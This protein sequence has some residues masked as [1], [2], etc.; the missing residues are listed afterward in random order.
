MSCTIRTEF[1]VDLPDVCLMPE[2]CVYRHGPLRCLAPDDNT[3]SLLVDALPDRAVLP[4]ARPGPRVVRT[5]GPV[6]SVQTPPRGLHVQPMPRG[7]QVSVDCSLLGGRLRLRV[8]ES[9]GERWRGID[10]LGEQLRRMCCSACQEDSLVGNA[11]V[12][13]LPQWNLVTRKEALRG[14]GAEGRGK[15]CSDWA[16]DVLAPFR[17][18][19]D[20][21]F[22]CRPCAHLQA[23]GGHVACS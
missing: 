3:P 17:L 19:F 4:C 23:R 10:D 9:S 11:R 2:P 16:S 15:N 18:A 5:T 6:D 1:A 21:G 12:R 7:V 20:H 13:P 22:R 8:Q 14:E